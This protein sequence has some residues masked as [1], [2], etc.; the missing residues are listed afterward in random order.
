MKKI[1]LEERIKWLED[2]NERWDA[3]N[4]RLDGHKDQD[5][6]C[7]ELHAFCEANSLPQESVDELLARAYEE[8]RGGG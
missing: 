3:A 7:G 8:M 6:M 2:F 5:A 4:D 1:G